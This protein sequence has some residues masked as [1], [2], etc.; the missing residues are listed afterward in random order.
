MTP[1][2]KLLDRLRE[3]ENRVAELEEEYEEDDV[4]DDEEDDGWL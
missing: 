2:R 3:L 4:D 1:K